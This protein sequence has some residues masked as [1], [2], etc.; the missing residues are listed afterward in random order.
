MKIWVVRVILLAVVVAIGVWVWKTF[1][2]GPEQAIR[3]NLKQFAQAISFSS[4]E[5]N[6]TRVADSQKAVSLCAS[7][8]DISI[9]A[10]GYP[11]QSITGSAELFQALMLARARLASLQVEFLDPNIRLAPNKDSA[12][13]DL[14]A[15]GRSP[16]ERD[17]QVMELKFTLQKVGNQWLIRK[18]ETVKTLSSFNR[19]APFRTRAADRHL[20][21]GRGQG[22]GDRRARV[23]GPH[24]AEA[25]QRGRRSVQLHGEGQGDG[26]SGVR[27][28]DLA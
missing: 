13:V 9:E 20:S 17:I 23:S 14:T 8:I 2:P 15:R 19:N 28:R 27:I 4:G 3:R 12:V 26:D 18:I 10:T 1:F 11:P 7:N 6:L 16:G 24:H 21:S 5:G 25:D 22:E